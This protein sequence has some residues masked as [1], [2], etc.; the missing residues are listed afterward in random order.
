MWD[1]KTKTEK[2][3]SQQQQANVERYLKSIYDA[4]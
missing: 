2:N 1:S 3:D 4:K